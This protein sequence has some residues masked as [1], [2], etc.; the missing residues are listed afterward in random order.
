MKRI[1]IAFMLCVMAFGV[2]AQS[3]ELIFTGRDTYGN[4][5]RLSQVDIENQSRNWTET[6]TWPDTTLLLIN[7]TD[8]VE[9]E[10]DIFP[11]VGQNVPNP[12]DGVTELAVNLAEGGSLHLSVYTVS[13]RLLSEYYG[14]MPSGVHRFRISVA[15]PQACVVVARSGVRQGS[16]KILNKGHGTIDRVEYLGS[17]VFVQ[18]GLSVELFGYGD[19]MRYVGYATISGSSRQ[20]NPVTQAQNGSETISLFFNSLPQITTETV[21]DITETT[22]T[23][24]GNVTHDGGATVTERGV[25]W[26]TSPNPE[27]NGSRT[28]ANSSGTGSFTVSL[29][30]LN[31][32]TTYYVRAYATNSVG[33][34]YGSEVSFTSG[35]G[36]PTVSTLSP[37]SDTDTSATCGGN[38]TNDGGSTVTERGIYWGTSPNPE[39]NGSRTPANGS[40]T[41]SFTVNLTG[42]TSGTTYYVKAYATNSAGT[43]Y[44]EEVSFTISFTCGIST[45]TD[46]DGNTY[47]TV[48]IGG[49]CWMKENLRTKKYADGTAILQGSESSTTTAYWYY[50]NDSS[51]NFSTY[52][53]LYNWKAVM[54]N[55]SSSSANPSGVQGICPTGWHVP[56]D[57]EWTQLTD[58]VSSQSQY[59]CG[60]DNTYIAKAL[61][62]TTGWNSSTTTCA[63]GNTPS[64]NNATGFDALPAGD[65][66][67][68][69][70]NFGEDAYFWSTTVSG[71]YPYFRDLFYNFAYVWRHSGYCDPSRGLSVRCLR[72]GGGSTASQVPTVTTS[73]TTASS[74]TS[75]SATCGGNVT[76]DG[77]ATVTERGVYWGTSPNPEVNGS[78]TSANGSGT[79]SFTVSLT[80]LTPNTTYYVKAYATNSVGTAYGEEVSF[81]TNSTS[82][83]TCGTSTLT[84]IDGN[85]YNTVQIGQQCWMKE[86]LRTKKYADGTA[87]SQGSSTSTTTGYWYYP[88]NNSSNMST[89]GLLY[90]WKAVMRTSTSSSANPSGVQG[91]CPTGWHVPSDAEWTQL[92]DYVSSQSQYVCGSNNTY[93][94]KALAGTTG[95]SSSTT[96]CAVGNTPSNN[97]ATGFNALPAGDYNGSYNDF[98]YGASFWSATE[99]S[100]SNAY[101]RNLNYSYADVYRN[102][103]SKYG[104][105]SVRCLRDGGGST[106]S[107]VPTV[108]TATVAASSITATSAV[109]GGNVTSDGGSTVTE[110]GIYWG[111]SPNPEVN[112]SHTPANGSGTGSFTVSLTGLTS[113]TT[114]YVKAYATNSVGTAYGSEVSFTTSTAS[115]GQDGQPCPNAATLTDIDG[116]TYNTVQIG[117][118]CW[119]KENLRTKKYADGTS[120]S[121]GSETSTTT[122]YWYY[123]NN[124]S[125]NMSTYGL[126]YNWKAVMRNSTSS[127]GN[128]SGVQGIC[129][130]GWHVPSD[131]EWTQLTN[132]V[133]SQS[134]YWCGGDS[135]Y[136]AKAL[137]ST[138]GWNS[139]TYTCD[140][141]NTSS[142][143][144]ATGFSALPSG[145]YNDSYYNF[146]HYASFWSTTE[147]SSSN[148]YRRNLYYSGAG[149]YRGNYSKY[150]GFSVRCLRVDLPTVIT[151]A[152]SITSTSATCGGN[153]TSD[154]ISTVTE[155]GVYWGTS[156]NP[157]LNGSR[158]PANGSGMGSFTVSL[159]GL[160]P[161]TIYYVKAYATNSAGTG[162]GSEVSFTPGDGQSCPNAA[163]LTDIDGN[164]YNTVQIGQ[165]CWMKENLRTKKYADGTAISQGSDTSTTT[166]YW[167]YPNNSSSNFSTYGL[168]Y[169]WPAVMRN[170]SSSSVN[171]SGVQGICPTGWHVPSNAEWTQLTN[172]VSSQ[173][174][175]VCGS[176]NTYIAKALA[177]TMGWNSCTDICAV[178]NTPS[179]NNATG[180]SALPAGLYRDSYGGNLGYDASFWSATEVVTSS[181]AYQSSLS[182]YSINVGRYGGPKNYGF[183]VRCLR[184]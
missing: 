152:S 30:G 169:N 116:N 60:S 75:T 123:P 31:A 20:S 165:Q 122:A 114:Y 154:G 164:T 178:G 63:V 79:G 171:P 163:T 64:G 113:G 118:Q 5:V 117:S 24:G 35:V 111:T 173:S 119:M 168:L 105:F 85:T 126:L 92:T 46:I 140:V 44:G 131:A 1:G 71:G 121:Q 6:L 166:G 112:G 96:T 82:S 25:Y 101:Y 69:C 167:Y 15:Q 43:A 4:Y 83:F 26:G 89:Y 86:N 147:S 61:A 17:D 87:I 127:S 102:D 95:W 8:I 11:F 159:T 142:N 149:V 179:G 128:P 98:G 56:S 176:D 120:I 45:L 13:G 151:T 22:A 72:D 7:V 27:V 84:D 76:N 74:I 78:R 57:A 68:R 40:G 107:Q 115:T 153:V 99:N 139:S 94:A 104:G 32:N 28:P 145:H 65:Y 135:T 143:N 148:A 18:K 106:A 48:Q 132:Y 36:L 55:S 183:S 3:V 80:G 129:P 37:S 62:S 110:R 162:Y 66:A 146:D 91:I 90:N 100:S 136:I 52:G 180:F 155:R 49:Q 38:V 14:E 177:G 174:Q 150:L 53:L 88:N 34:A 21:S 157:E 97:N 125:S 42:L 144:N 130:T 124:N 54:R 12:F 47:N 9:N 41:G 39:V 59:V 108:T 160:T 141:G 58:Y 170:S 16:A 51:S 73:T 138:T 109:C 2:Y 103:Y 175:Y 172:Y 81:T 29:T 93:I 19:N 156:P 184:D 137:A 161:G 33:T 182:Y 70:I 10:T 23:C 133:S 50:P 134:Q 158:T 67:N 181:Y 77:G